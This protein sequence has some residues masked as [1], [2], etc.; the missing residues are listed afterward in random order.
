MW[1]ANENSRTRVPRRGNGLKRKNHMQCMCR[2]WQTV[3]CYQNR[4]WTWGLWSYPSQRSQT[5]WTWGAPTSQL[6]PMG[7]SLGQEESSVSPHPF[8]YQN[9]GHPQQCFY[10]K[11]YPFC[12]LWWICIKLKLQAVSSQCHS[13]WH[14]QRPTHP[15]PGSIHK[16]TWLIH[17]AT[18]LSST[19]PILQRE[20]MRF[21]ERTWLAYSPMSHTERV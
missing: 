6:L 21:T 14:A 7:T 15:G 5:S 16:S 4:F 11:C 2:K 17:K 20:K 12:E 1:P 9:L 19:I 13:F 10:L 8:S 3:P 18:Q